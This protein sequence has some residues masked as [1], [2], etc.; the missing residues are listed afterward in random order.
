MKI[1]GTNFIEEKINATDKRKTN[2]RNELTA[3]ERIR[4][5]FFNNPLKE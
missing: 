2:L 5:Y 4:G 3:I 1:T